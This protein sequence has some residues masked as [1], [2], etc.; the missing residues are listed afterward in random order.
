MIEKYLKLILE[1]EDENNQDTQNPAP[2]EKRKLKTLEEIK[3]YLE[4]GKNQIITK[5]KCQIFLDKTLY[6]ENQ[7][8]STSEYYILPGILELYF[9]EDDTIIDLPFTF[10]IHLYKPETIIEGKD[11]ILLEYEPGDILIKQKYKSTMSNFDLL[12]SLLEGSTKY[13]KNPEKLVLTL[14][15]LLNNS[16]DL[17]VF[18]LIVSHIYRC[19]DDLKKPARLCGYENAEF[20]GI[21]KI[22]YIDSWLLG[23]EFERIDDAIKNAL[24]NNTGLSDTVYEKLFLE[25]WF[26]F[27]I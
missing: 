5:K 13:I 25:F 6:K 14:S 18:E 1:E 9:P 20:V 26:V 3:N 4:I 7:L 27:I 16:I 12:T 22:P 8:I 11:F 2:S 17:V 15:E 19:K 24:K 23:I 21:R 10:D